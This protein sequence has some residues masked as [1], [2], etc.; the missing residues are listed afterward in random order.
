MV[1]DTDFDTR[2]L[3]YLQQFR[4]VCASMTFPILIYSGRRTPGEQNILF[5]RGRTTM[6]PNPGPSHPLGH[7]VTNARGTPP[8]TPHIFGLAFDGC[9][10]IGGK[11][12]WDE[13]LT[14]AH[15]TQYGTLCRAV[16]MEWGGDW[17][18][19]RE[20]PHCQMPQWKTYA[21]VP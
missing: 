11:P 15:W 1:N 12:A 16:G 7:T 4:A 6:G 3:P 2:F 21:S 17:V 10:T 8:Q 13:P 18:G 20:G 19:F 5:E 14:G 9:P